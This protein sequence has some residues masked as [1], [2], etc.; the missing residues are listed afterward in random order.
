MR[1][2][3]YVVLVYFGLVE[4]PRAAPLR[5]TFAQR[6]L[7]YFTLGLGVSTVLLLIQG[8]L[9][10]ALVVAVCALLLVA[11]AVLRRRRRR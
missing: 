10:S 3:L 11:V 5:G 8:E 1:R 7:E 6:F 4:D 2:R 9:G